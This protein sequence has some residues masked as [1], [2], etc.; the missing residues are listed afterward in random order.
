MDILNYFINKSGYPGYSAIP[1][2]ENFP[3]PTFMEDEEIKKTVTPLQTRKLK[4]NSKAEIFLSNW[5]R[6]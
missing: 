2:P 5:P 4:P 3:R 1:L 6:S